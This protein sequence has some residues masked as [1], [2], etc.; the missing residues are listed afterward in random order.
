ML[1]GVNEDLSSA[2]LSKIN[3]TVTLVVCDT[4]FADF[5]LSRWWLFRCC[6]LFPVKWTVFFVASLKKKIFK[7]N[8]K[9]FG[10]CLKKNAGPCLSWT[11]Y[12]VKIWK[13]WLL[14]V[15]LSIGFWLNSCWN[16]SRQI[17]NCMWNCY[18]LKL[19]CCLKLELF[20]WRRIGK[21]FCF[22]TEGVIGFR[23]FMY[24]KRSA[25]VFDGWISVGSSLF[26][27]MYIHVSTVAANL[28]SACLE[29]LPQVH[30]LV[31]QSSSVKRQYYYLKIKTKLLIPN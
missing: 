17:N 26:L 24:I 19:S 25:S 29:C 30:K 18:F 22:Y 11:R 16:V 31:L 4:F 12:P 28:S 3:C 21:W 20:S 7:K 9:S 14:F 2:I 8:N 5:R 15:L 6:Y 13:L 1:Q 23:V 10:P 27:Y